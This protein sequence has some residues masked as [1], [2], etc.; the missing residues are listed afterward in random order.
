MSGAATAL[1][2]LVQ[3]LPIQ[4]CDLYIQHPLA[5]ILYRCVNPLVC[6]VFV[7]YIW[8]KLQMLP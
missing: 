2:L 8:Y 5:Y 7:L 3:A 6:R 1:V 4:S